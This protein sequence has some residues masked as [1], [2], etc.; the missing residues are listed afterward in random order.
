MVHA[1]FYWTGRGT[2]QGTLPAQFPVPEVPGNA[3]A[4]VQRLR[5]RGTAC[6]FT[7]SRTSLGPTNRHRVQLSEGRLK[8]IHGLADKWQRET[9]LVLVPFRGVH[10]ARAGAAVVPDRPARNL[11]RLGPAPSTQSQPD[12]SAEDRDELGPLHPLIERPYN[13]FQVYSDTSYLYDS[14]ILLTFHKPVGDRCW[15]RFSARRIP[16][17]FLTTSRPTFYAQQYIRS[18]RQ[19]EFLRFLR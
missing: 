9:F 16:R 14:N 13:P 4:A 1:S 15:T 10:G 5:D 11:A 19:Q 6:C 3:N 18:V 7:S 17:E 8:E 2:Q 12:E